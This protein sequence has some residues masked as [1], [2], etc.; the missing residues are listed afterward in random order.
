MRRGYDVLINV[1]KHGFPYFFVG[2][3]IEAEWT[4]SSGRPGVVFPYFFV[5]T[6]IEAKN[7]V[8]RALPLFIFPY[9]FVGTFIEASKIS[10][11]GA[12][13]TNFPTFS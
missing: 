5:G 12:L 11:L 9:F 13:Y 2:T 1:G 6:F 8:T 3:F 10:P 7:A 4:S